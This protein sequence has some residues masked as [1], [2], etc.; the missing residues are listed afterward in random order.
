MQQSESI[1]RGRRAS[2]AFTRTLSKNRSTLGRSARSIQRCRD[3]RRM[4]LDGASQRSQRTDR[5]RTG[6]SSAGIDRAACALEF[7]LLENVLDA[8]ETGGERLEIGRSA[9]RLDARQA[10]FHIQQIVP[11][12]GQDGVD[13]VVVE[14]A[15]VAEI[16]TG[17]DRARIAR[18]SAV[19][20]TRAADSRACLRPGS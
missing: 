17:R 8:F 9:H 20:G 7:G 11:A 15:N 19:R 13:F 3:S 18:A 4:Y 6:S 10:R 5:L 16:V 14:A 1:L 2:G 12:G